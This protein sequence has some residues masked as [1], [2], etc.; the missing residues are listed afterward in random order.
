M[1]NREKGYRHY[2][3]ERDEVIRTMEYCR[4]HYRDEQD[5]FTEC[6]K[7]VN[8][9]ISELLV[10]SV[11]KKLSYERLDARVG[12]PLH[13]NDFYGYRRKYIWTVSERLKGVH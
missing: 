10:W 7:A 8:P 9:E 12:I 5:F 13:K 2:Q 3:L 11:G 1:R 6:A 4:T